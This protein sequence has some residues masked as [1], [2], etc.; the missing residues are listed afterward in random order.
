MDNERYSEPNWERKY[1]NLKIEFNK[2][3]A[4]LDAG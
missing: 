2:L 1:N 4:E 3:K